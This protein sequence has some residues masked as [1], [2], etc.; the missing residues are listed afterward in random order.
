MKFLLLAVA[1]VAH[2]FAMPAQEAENV[3]ANRGLPQPGENAGVT[4]ASAAAAAYSPAQNG[5]VSSPDTAGPK[6]GIL[7]RHLINAPLGRLYNYR[8]KDASLLHQTRYCEFIAGKLRRLLHAY[9]KRAYSLDDMA[10]LCKRNDV[11]MNALCKELAVSAGLKSALFL[12]LYNSYVAMCGKLAAYDSL[13][14]NASQL[15]D[16]ISAFPDAPRMALNPL[17]SSA[18]FDSERYLNYVEK[19]KRNLQSSISEPCYIPISMPLEDARVYED[20]ASSARSHIEAI[21]KKMLE[22]LVRIPEHVYVSPCIPSETIGT[23]CKKI[24]DAYLFILFELKCFKDHLCSVKIRADADE[25]MTKAAQQIDFNIQFQLKHALYSSI[26]YGTIEDML[27]TDELVQIL[28]ESHFKG[29]R[30]RE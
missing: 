10:C 6:P 29:D 25:L 12:D 9:I 30:K 4:C 20:F 23:M 27:N 17:Q 8:V 18:A 1:L 5:R 13:I 19:L 21:T 28:V 11:D 2:M 14:T 22:K 3:A 26:A 16:T 15:L 24:R 7:L